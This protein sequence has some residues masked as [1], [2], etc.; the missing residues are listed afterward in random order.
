MNSVF[1]AGTAKVRNWSK[2]VKSRFV[3][4]T[5]I[6]MTLA[7]VLVISDSWKTCASERVQQRTDDAYVRADL[8]PLSTN[9][10]GLLA[11]V[12][13][14]DCQAVKVGDLLVRLRHEDFR[15][16][17]QRAES[18]VAASESTLVNNQR[19]K[20]LQD[21]RIMQAQTGSKLWSRILPPRKQVLT[22]ANSAMANV[23]SATATTQADVQRAIGVRARGRRTR[24]GGRANAGPLVITTFGRRNFMIQSKRD[25]L[26]PGNWIQA[27]TTALLIVDERCPT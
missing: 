15:A 27:S 14:A 17:M 9:V 1:E 11:E 19:Q 22:P 10:A 24:A 18:A 25:L 2:R 12:K 4:A 6:A 8:T 20:N 13:V 23:R 5:V 21:I 26:I 16:Q 7:L 3:P